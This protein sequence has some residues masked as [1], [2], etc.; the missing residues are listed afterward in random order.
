MQELVARHYR[1]VSVSWT[2]HRES[3]TGL[4]QTYTQDERFREFY[5]NY[6]PGLASFLAEAITVYAA[7]NL[8]E[9]S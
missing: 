9:E 1:W 6:Q 8:T 7:V 4:A 2:P 5:D 3:Y